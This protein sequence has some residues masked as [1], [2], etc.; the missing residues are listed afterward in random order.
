MATVT[1]K[2]NA[3]GSVTGTWQIVGGAGSRHASVSHG[4]SSPDDNQY[5][6]NNMNEGDTNEHMYLGFENMPA[7]FDEITAVTMKIRQKIY[8]QAGQDGVKYQLFQSNGTTALSNQ[9]SL[10]ADGSDISSS[11]RTDTVNF[12]RTG[13]TS[14]ATWHGVQLKVIHDG[15]GDGDDPDYSVSEIQLE[16]TYNTASAPEIVM[17]GLDDE[18]IADG[19]SSATTTDGTDFGTIS[20]GGSTVTRT[21]KVTNTGDADL[22][23]GTPSLPTGFTL[24]EG[25]DST[26]SASANDTFSV[27]LDNSVVGTKTGQISIENNDADEDPFNFTITGEVTAAAAPSTSSVAVTNALL[28]PSLVGV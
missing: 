21:F 14:K 27:R 23:L 28:R 22:T 24:T 6:R 2:P 5:V 13:S 7:D 25:L 8:V 16:I 20:A 9:I 26:I 19:D 17:T 11:F 15:P 10:D 4:T 12:T 3:D 1:V 18:N